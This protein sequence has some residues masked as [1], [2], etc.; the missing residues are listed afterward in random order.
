MS[1][2]DQQPK[3]DP[4]GGGWGVH[5]SANRPVFWCHLPTGSQTPHHG[6]CARLCSPCPASDAYPYPS[7]HNTAN[8]PRNPS[9]SRSASAQTNPT[10][11]PERPRARN[12][13]PPGKKAPAWLSPMA[14]TVS[15]EWEWSHRPMPA[16]GAALSDE[17]GSANLVASRAASEAAAEAPKRAYTYWH[18]H[19]HTEGCTHVRT[20]DSMTPVSGP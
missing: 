11:L 10:A 2:L 19:P 5:A 20:S 17:G 8:R 14:Q 13:D 4:H 6:V 7:P 18:T 3:T 15:L 16:S 9:D 12:D 1:R